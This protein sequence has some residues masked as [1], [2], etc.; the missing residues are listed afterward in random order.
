MRRP[1]AADKWRPPGQE[2]APR[3]IIIARAAIPPKA[4]FLFADAV[5]DRRDKNKV[6][7]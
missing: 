7:A 2:V 6:R 1:R 5:R 4:N 3:A